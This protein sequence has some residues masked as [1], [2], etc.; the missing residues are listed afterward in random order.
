MKR[1]LLIL[2]I[3][4]LLVLALPSVVGAAATVVTWESYTTGADNTTTVYGGHWMCQTFTVEQES[5][6]ALWVRLSMYRLGEPGTAVIGLREVDSSGFPTGDDLT[7]GTIDADVMSNSTAAWYTVVL[8][9]YSLSYNTSYAIVISAEGGDASNAL[10]VMSD[11]SAATYAGGTKIYSTTGGLIWL[12]DTGHDL[13][14]SVSGRALIDIPDVKVFQDYYEDGDMLFTI[15]YENFYVPYYPTDNAPSYFRLQLRDTDGTTLISQTVCRQWGY[16]PAEIYLSA[17]TAAPLDSGQDYMIVL[18]GSNLY[19]VPTT[20]YTL[21]SDDW[22]GSD[23]S[24]LQ[25]WAINLAKDMEEYYDI[26][27]VVV[28]GKS[29]MLNEQAGVFFLTGMP[30]LVQLVPN[31]FA[32][33]AVDIDDY[34]TDPYD[35]DTETTW[36]AEVGDTVAGAVGYTAN[37]LGIDEPQHLAGILLMIG[38]FILAGVV[39]AKG[40][41]MSIAAFLAIPVILAG[42]QLR[43]FPFA[44][45]AA[46]SGIAI[47]LLVYRFWWSRT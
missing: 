35:W 9:E 34:S 47:L 1:L 15:A 33:G 21:A 32:V 30:S 26:E 16:M 31:I 23:L 45:I 7:T 8:D 6:S 39:V 37:I 14:F 42:T 13:Q 18:E 27:L 43:I 29:E 3:V 2:P 24:Q 22:K 17:D 11:D 25:T 41:D 20:N 44:F 38:Y 4:L 19:E 28:S 5:H 46:I 36:D 10:Y 40:G 12:E